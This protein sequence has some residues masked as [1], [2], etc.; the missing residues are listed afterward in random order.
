MNIFF[1]IINF[2]I[3]VSLGFFLNYV[4]VRFNLEYK[5]TFIANKINKKIY[6]KTVENDLLLEK[7]IEIF[8]II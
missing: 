4:K 8:L 1:P 6:L 7:S 5:V 2:V 3:H